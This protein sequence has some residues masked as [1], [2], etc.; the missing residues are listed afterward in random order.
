MKG[1]HTHTHA[2]THARTHTHTCARADQ[3]P[4]TPTHPPKKGGEERH[5]YTVPT[6]SDKKKRDRRESVYCLHS[7][8]IIHAPLCTRALLDYLPLTPLAQKKSQIDTLLQTHFQL[9]WLRHRTADLSEQK[10]AGFIARARNIRA[11]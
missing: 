8:H 9:S 3:R 10:N 6:Q 1:T 11:N 5:T 4:L 2:R 7:S